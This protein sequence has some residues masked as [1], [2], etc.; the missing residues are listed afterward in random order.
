MLVEVMV[1]DELK[2]NV[3]EKLCT[4]ANLSAP[5][6]GEMP[7]FAPMFK[8]FCFVDWPPSIAERCTYYHFV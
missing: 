5:M 3:A 6:Q 2:R 1:N 7:N 8:Q 4:S